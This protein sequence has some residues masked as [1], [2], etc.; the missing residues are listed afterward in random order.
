GRATTREL[1]KTPGL[2]GEIRQPSSRYL[3]LPKVSSE[4]RAYIPCGFLSPDAIASG[5]SV[6]VAGAGRHDFGVITSQMHMAWMR[7]VAGRLESR[8]QYSAGIV[9][10]NF[11]WPELPDATHK[12]DSRL[13]GNDELERR[14][15]D[16]QRARGNDAQA[17]R[18]Q[19]AQGQ[20]HRAAI[21]AAA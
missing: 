2:F 15:D 8:Y 1:A 13:R 5:T 7:A 11:P 14:V 16:E 18:A 17:A 10:N 4:N 12:S 9:Y 3:L 19:D 6:V 20:K 21:E